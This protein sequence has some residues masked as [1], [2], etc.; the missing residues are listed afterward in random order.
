MASGLAKMQF[1][2]V[3]GAKRSATEIASS[4]TTKLNSASIAVNI[5]R[6]YT[7]SIKKI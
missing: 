2:Y 1:V 3:R 5:D 6:P 7:L 4:F